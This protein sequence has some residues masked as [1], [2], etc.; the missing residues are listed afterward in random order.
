MPDGDVLIHAG[1][2]TQNGE[3]SEVRDFN[4]WLGTLPHKHK[5]VIAGNHDFCLADALPSAQELLSNAT[6]L[7]DQAVVIEGIRFYGSPWQP[8][9]CDMAFNLSSDAQL[10]AKWS[11]IPE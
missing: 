10:Q 5:L 3:V 7:Q 11:L 4:R 9:F 1:D 6:Y 2:M 8:S